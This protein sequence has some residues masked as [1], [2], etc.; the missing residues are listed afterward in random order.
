MLKWRKVTNR[1]KIVLVTVLA[2]GDA[3]KYV[4]PMHSQFG[5]SVPFALFL[6]SRAILHHRY[7][8]S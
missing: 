3:T 4:I 5:R 6:H 1:L 2:K 7:G 8:I